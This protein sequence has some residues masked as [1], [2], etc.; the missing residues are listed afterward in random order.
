MEFLETFQVRFE[1][2]KSSFCIQVSALP[3]ALAALRD[4]ALVPLRPIFER[5]A[6]VRRQ[7]VV[8]ARPVRARIARR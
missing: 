4:G 8:G 7:V 2:P 5:L 1:S 6:L 3:L